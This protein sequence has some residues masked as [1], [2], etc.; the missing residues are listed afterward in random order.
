VLSSDFERD[1]RRPAR[2]N[3]QSRLSSCA[4]SLTQAGVKRSTVARGRNE[5]NEARQAKVPTAAEAR[6]IAINIARP[7]KLLGKG[8][9]Y[10]RRDGLFRLPF[11][12]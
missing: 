12:G 2:A 7:P 6:P 1:A 8:P 4:L 9:E 10:D 5:R 3:R 11:A